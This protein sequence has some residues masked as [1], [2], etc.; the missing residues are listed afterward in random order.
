MHYDPCRD[1]AP[2]PRFANLPRCATHVKDPILPRATAA[3]E[4]FFKS[5][6]LTRTPSEGEPAPFSLDG[7]DLTD[8]A[9]GAFAAHVST[10]GVSAHISFKT[11]N[12]DPAATPP[13]GDG[14]FETIRA[15]LSRPQPL[16]CGL[17][18]ESLAT[19]F[20]DPC[21]RLRP[22]SLAR[23]SCLAE[24][25]RAAGVRVCAVDPGLTDWITAFALTPFTRRGRNALPAQRG[26]GRW[27]SQRVFVESTPGYRDATGKCRAACKARK[28]M[29]RQHPVD[30]ARMHR[31]IP[32]GRVAD[33][34]AFALHCRRKLAAFEAGR[35]LYGSMQARQARLRGGILE[36]RH[37]H[38]LAQTLAWGTSIVKG[39]WSP[40]LP[41]PQGLPLVSI[42]GWGAANIGAGSAISRAG[43]GPSRKFERF[44]R[45]HY[46]RVFFVRVA[47]YFTSRLCTSCLKLRPK[48]TANVHLGGR[49]SHKL[50]VCNDHT[51]PLV[52]DRDASA[53]FA[54]MTVLLS[55]LFTGD[56]P[57]WQRRR[58]AA[59]ADSP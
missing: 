54:I 47:E 22:Q 27:L 13:D 2:F 48:G 5:A 26:I 38:R 53:S 4:A 24:D 55:R 49:P 17:D 11:H 33:P 56:P 18:M 31:C 45:T 44:V 21:R 59:P 12:R 32:P 39:K 8:F 52:V 23:L 1:A 30:R 50:L 29:R 57:E 25:L 16:G 9:A 40:R 7:K 14:L 37:F 35:R 20:D 46:P 51:P 42:I 41:V 19:A 34:A 6:T 3:W 15:K 36:R 43:M 28:R 10:D 58:K